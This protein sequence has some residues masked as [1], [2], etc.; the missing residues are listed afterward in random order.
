[1]CLR[2]NYICVFIALSRRGEL[3]SPV[4]SVQNKREGTETLPYKIPFKFYETLLTC[5]VGCGVPD[6]PLITMK[7]L[8]I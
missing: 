6:T 5:V 8:L 1:M 7:I 4:I 3:C 2:R